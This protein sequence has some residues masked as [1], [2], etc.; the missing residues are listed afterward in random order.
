MHT[1]IKWPTSVVVVGHY[2]KTFVNSN[3]VQ[4]LLVACACVSRVGPVQSNQRVGGV[5][6]KRLPQGKLE[7]PL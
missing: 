6:G 1:F 5:P 4:Q 7:Q 2:L 3:H